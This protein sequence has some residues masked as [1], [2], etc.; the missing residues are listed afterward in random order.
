MRALWYLLMTMADH[1]EV[2]KL[3]IVRIV[4]FLD[5][6][7]PDG[8]DYEI[9]RVITL[10]WS[11]VPIRT[12]SLY[13]V[14]HQSIWDH[15]IDAGLL[16]VSPFVRLRTRAIHGKI[17]KTMKRGIASLQEDVV[18]SHFFRLFAHLCSLRLRVSLLCILGSLSECKYT[19][20]CLGVPDNSLPVGDD[21]QLR[22]E[23]H[24]QWLRERE[25]L[26]GTTIQRDAFLAG[27]S[28]AAK[29]TIP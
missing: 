9:L 20:M 3:G 8:V 12:V 28:P 17:R 15:A 21:G 7:P 24:N 14:S 22:L 10:I 1:E 27:R 6:Y 2:Q 11:S 23:N 19:L 5:G 29:S 18:S 16:M 26:E 25:S 13:I 4:Y